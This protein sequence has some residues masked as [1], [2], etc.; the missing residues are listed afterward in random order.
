MNKFLDE[1]GDYIEDYEIGDLDFKYSVEGDG[2]S[3]R[4]LGA[5][6][7]KR[8]IFELTHVDSKFELKYGERV[9]TQQASVDLMRFEIRNRELIEKRFSLGALCMWNKFFSQEGKD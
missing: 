1:E 3:T 9:D 7:D 2:G 4:V 5:Y 6:Q 8:M